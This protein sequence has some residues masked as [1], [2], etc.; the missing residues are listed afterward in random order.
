VIAPK[1]DDTSAAHRSDVTV[2]PSNVIIFLLFSSV[3]YT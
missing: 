2:L 3:I 1:G